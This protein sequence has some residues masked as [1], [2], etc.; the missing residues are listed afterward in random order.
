[1]LL[2]LHATTASKRKNTPPRPSIHKAVDTASD[3]IETALAIFISAGKPPQIRQAEGKKLGSS[4]AAGR[5]IPAV[6][7]EEGRHTARHYE[8]KRNES[9]PTTTT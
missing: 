9:K 6:E 3:F 1:V 4:V 5:R 8:N 7:E 2:P